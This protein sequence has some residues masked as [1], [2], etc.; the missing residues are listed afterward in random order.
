MSLVFFYSTLME[1][2]DMS[3]GL[4]NLYIDRKL[5]QILSLPYYSR[6]E[7]TI[8]LTSKYDICL[9]PSEEIY[10]DTQWQIREEGLVDYAL[11]IKACQID[12]LA[13]NQRDTP[14]EVT[15]LHPNYVGCIQ[16]FIKNISSECVRIGKGHTL[17]QLMIV[18][19]Y[20]CQ[21]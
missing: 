6:L 8:Y 18:P 5:I 21:K 16:L 7:Y 12:G 13:I 14:H 1:Q 11:W 4:P 3:Q 2:I 10:C 20:S 17:G 19:Y 9:K 15:I